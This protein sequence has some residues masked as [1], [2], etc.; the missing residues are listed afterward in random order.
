MTFFAYIFYIRLHNNII[1]VICHV[2]GNK[3]GTFYL[4]Y[5]KQSVP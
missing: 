4:P 3:Q 5:G 2:S 1:A